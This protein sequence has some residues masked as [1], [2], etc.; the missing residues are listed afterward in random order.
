MHEPTELVAE[1]EVAVVRPHVWGRDPIHALLLSMCLQ[2]VERDAVDRDSTLLLAVF[3]GPM[4][5]SPRTVV[6]V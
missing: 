5:M 1:D 6:S 2:S 3:G 4:C